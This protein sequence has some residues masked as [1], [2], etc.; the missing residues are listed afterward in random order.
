MP[1]SNVST[2]ISWTRQ[3]YTRRR[4]PTWS[5]DHDKIPGQQS[6][7]LPVESLV[8]LALCPGADSRDICS[9]RVVADYRAVCTSCRSS[10]NKSTGRLNKVSWRDNCSIPSRIR[11]LCT[12][13]MYNNPSCAFHRYHFKKLTSDSLTSLTPTTEHNARP[14]R[15]LPFLHRCGSTC[16]LCGEGCGWQVSDR[17]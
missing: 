1:P 2:R 8:K 5:R 12:N 3:V 11:K 6:S 17:P 7:E 9:A 13:I 14:H 16:E 10:R 4:A 15:E